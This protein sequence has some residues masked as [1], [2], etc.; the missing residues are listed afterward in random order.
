MTDEKLFNRFLDVIENDIVPLTEK[1]VKTGSKVFGAAVLRKK[2]LSLVLSATNHEALSPLWHGEVYTI[3]L[4]FE[5]QG[6]PD[7]A[8]CIF[9]STHQPC[10]M[11]ASALAWSGFKE[12]YY[13][14]GYEHTDADFNIPHDR[15]M[16]LDI[17]GCAAP[18]A[19]NTYF[20]WASLYEMMETLP[21]PAAARRRFETLRVT[22]ARLSDTYQNGEK[23]MILT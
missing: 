11:C 18:N 7:P 15:K 10:C 1:G 14:F 13:L 3:K 2:D 9:L 16:I 6:H 5:L 23:K 21:E 20:S 8:E 12:I 4:F 22:Y 19:K 17:F